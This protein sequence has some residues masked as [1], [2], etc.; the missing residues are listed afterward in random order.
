M[1]ILRLAAA[2]IISGA[3]LGAW[4]QQAGACEGYMP[5]LSIGAEGRVRAGS[6]NNV[7]AQPDRDAER[8]GEIPA[9]GVF[10]VVDGA[11]CSDGLT[12]WLVDY[13][14]LIGWTAEANE[15]DVF[16]EPLSGLGTGGGS[17]TSAPD[18]SGRF[19]PPDVIAALAVTG[20]GGGGFPA[21]ASHICRAVFVEY[22]AN[23]D[24]N[25][26]APS[27]EHVGIVGLSAGS[28]AATLYEYGENVPITQYTSGDV[29]AGVNLLPIGYYSVDFDFAPAIC[30]VNGDV[31]DANAIAPDGTVHEAMIQMLEGVTQVSLPVDAAY[32]PGVW[33]L[34]AAGLSAQIEIVLDEASVAQQWYDSETTPDGYGGGI[35]RVV[36][37]GYQPEEEIVLIA[38][39]GGAVTVRTD[40]RGY[41]SHTFAADEMPFQF[42]AIVPS[43]G[44]NIAASPIN[45]PNRETPQYNIPAAAVGEILH[46]VIYNGGTFDAAS[47]TCPGSGAPSLQWYGYARVNVD[48]LAMTDAP[49]VNSAPVITL[50]AGD[51]ITVIDGVE[52]ADS[53]TWWL[54]TF[55][56]ADGSAYYGWIP[57]GDAGGEYVVFDGVE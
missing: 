24:T 7:R 51:R 33:T 31:S 46:D 12:Y 36:L 2:L 48:A 25:I 34:E 44:E 38:D 55:T 13:D 56:A 26:F 20:G 35:S 40:A 53:M 47:W 29:I 21:L 28:S 57:Q 23:T 27:V 18:G 45:M 54:G 4:A 8:I 39:I 10:T 32:T 5:V 17:E 9:G 11:V 43:S 3:V 22:D 15:T 14:G 19:V 42:A 30:S 1:R 37:G 52:C 41:A 49:T 6:A 16:L 50:A